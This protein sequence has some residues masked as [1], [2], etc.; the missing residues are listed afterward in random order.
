MMQAEPIAQQI[1]D[2]LAAQLSHVLQIKARAVGTDGHVLRR[3]VDQQALGG[4]HMPGT[5]RETFLES[6]EILT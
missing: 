1:I 4:L 6:R 2:P 5:A 3:Q